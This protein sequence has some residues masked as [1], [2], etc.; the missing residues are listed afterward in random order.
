[1]K[2]LNINTPEILSEISRTSRL[3]SK[4]VEKFVF[5]WNY[6]KGYGLEQ[7]KTITGKTFSTGYGADSV[8]IPN[9]SRNY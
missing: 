1:M 5:L 6:F 7:G 8:A 4:S 2:N 9:F 3:F